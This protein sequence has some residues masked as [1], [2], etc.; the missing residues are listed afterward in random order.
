MYFRRNHRLF[1]I[2]GYFIKNRYTDNLVFV[3]YKEDKPVFVCEK[4]II[5]E[6]RFMKEYSANDYNHC[7][8]IAVMVR[9]V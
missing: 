7:F 5:Q 6:Q 4:G 9:I 2:E 8:F 3:S 1:C